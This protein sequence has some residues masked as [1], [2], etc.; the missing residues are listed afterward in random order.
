MQLRETLTLIPTILVSAM[1]TV[2]LGQPAHV[3]QTGQ[4]ESFAPGDDGAIQAG[5]PWPTPRFRDQGNGTVRDQL[6]GLIW[7]RNANCFGNVA[8]AQALTAANTLARGQ[9]GLTD[10]SAAG[11]W[12]LPTIMELQSLIDIGFAS[13]S[14]SNAAGTAQWTEGDPFAGVVS[15]ISLTYWSSTTSE[16]EIESAWGVFL[17]TDGEILATLKAVAAGIPWPVRGGR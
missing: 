4:T 14:L 17:G 6:T 12:R 7:L 9:C 13:P 16:G 8:W 15:N 2:A 3:P 10:G 1:L 11:D 5:V